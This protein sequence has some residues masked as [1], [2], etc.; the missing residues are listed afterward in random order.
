MIT[1]EKAS[2]DE[3]EKKKNEEEIEL[4]NETKNKS[5]TLR[6]DIQNI[7]ANTFK[8]IEKNKV[9]YFGEDTTIYQEVKLNS[10]FNNIDLISN[11]VPI[12][13]GYTK[14]IKGEYFIEIKYFP[15]R[16]YSFS[17]FDK[18][19]IMLNKIMVYSKYKNIDTKLLLFIRYDGKEIN[20]SEFQKIQEY[21][22]PAIENKYLE[23]ILM[24]INENN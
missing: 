19:Y 21:F 12:Y 17:L 14:C 24:D 8:H 6:Q 16:F 4:K 2:K 22:Q 9:K 5:T 15:T 11:H 18:L 20:K 13:D 23:V 3:I 10:V 7:E 1:T